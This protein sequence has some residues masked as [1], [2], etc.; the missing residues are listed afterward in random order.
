MI[1]NLSFPLCSELISSATCMQSS[2]VGV[3]IIACMCHCLGLRTSIKGIPKAAVLPVQ[4]CAC[5]I[6]SNSHFNNSG[7]V[8]VCIGDGS[9]NHFFSKASKVDCDNQKILNF[10]KFV[11]NNNIFIKILFLSYSYCGLDYR[12]E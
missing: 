10:S 4:V 1:D 5:H 3:T 9:S 11:I 7:I 8:S 6:I 12:A 2:L